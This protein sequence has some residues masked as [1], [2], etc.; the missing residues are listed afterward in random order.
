MAQSA[1]SATSV[2]AI[3]VLQIWMARLN[4]AS[5]APE[6]SRICSHPADSSPQVTPRTRA[7]DPRRCSRGPSR[8][9][10]ASPA[11]SSR[12][13]VLRSSSVVRNVA[14]G[15]KH[16]K[17]G[18]STGSS[19]GV[20]VGPFKVAQP[21]RPSRTVRHLTRCN[22]RPSSSW[23]SPRASSSSPASRLRICE[24]N[25]TSKAPVSARPSFETSKYSAS[26]AR[27]LRRSNAPNGA[28]SRKARGAASS[29][30]APAPP[31]ATKAAK[32]SSVTSPVPSESSANSRSPSRA[33]SP[34]REAAR[35]A[36]SERWMARDAARPSSAATTLAAARHLRSTPC[37]RS[38]SRANSTFACV[39]RPSP[40]TTARCASATALRAAAAWAC[41]SHSRPT[42]TS[43]SA[44]QGPAKAATWPSAR[45]S[46]SPASRT[47]RCE[48]ARPRSRAAPRRRSSSDCEA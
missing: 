1:R 35:S 23:A 30:T 40:C 20:P 7:S 18:F 8:S 33:P 29:G 39:S 41:S 46:A 5:S 15:C 34:P 45:C 48:S 42:W 19:C 16:Q 32:R 4:R 14:P 44:A 31:S 10:S 22:P 9:S 26:A 3:A 2:M 24:A 25:W 17:K 13:T 6:A 47:A 28:S 21:V 37:S 12:T 11:S 27:K 43:A 38:C 36:Q